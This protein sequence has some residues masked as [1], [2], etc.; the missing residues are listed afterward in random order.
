M[1]TTDH[2]PL[3]AIAMLAARAD[4]RTDST[5]QQAVDAVVERIGNPDVTRLAQQVAAGQLR[6]ADLAS[7]LSDDEARRVAYEGALA[8]CNSD[9]VVNASESAFLEELRTALGFSAASVAEAGKTASAL[10]GAP[11]AEVHTGTPP[12]GPLD[13][14]ILQQAMLTGALE[15]L[16][17]RLATVAVLPLQLRLVYQIGQRH[18]QKLDVNQVKDLAA[19]LGLGA[20]AQGMESVVLKIAGGIA[21][22]LLGGLVGG[23]ARV[24][25]GAVITFAATFALGH[26]SDQYYRQGRTLSAGDLRALFSRFQ[27]E[28]KTIYPRVEQQIRAQ[29]S[30]LNLQSLLQGLRTA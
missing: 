6:V 12:G 3:I 28:A 24:A 21:G 23:A 1:N 25:T 5:E 30:T 29:S 10:A 27:Q 15:I 22:G 20:A 2:A 13:D 8:I 4:G 17:D 16:P 18:G 11:V 26:V 9:G 19:T 7:R 14:F